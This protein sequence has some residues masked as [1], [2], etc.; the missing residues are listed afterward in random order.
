MRIFCTGTSGYIG[1]SVAATLVA[2]GH[3]VSG[4]VRST[5][6]AEQVRSIGIEP[7]HGALDDLDCL[8]AAAKAADVIVNAASADHRGAATALLQALEGTGK[9]Y[10]HT[11]GSSIVGTRSAGTRSDLVYNEESPFTP[12]PGR[13]ARVV[14]NE[15]IL[16]HTGK[17]L[18]PIII[19]PSLI[20]GLGHGVKR[21]SM[22]VP[23]LI[24]VAKKH[25][26]SKHYGPG[27]NIWSNVHIDDVV[28][29]YLL[30]MANAPAGA[31]YFAE[32]GENSMREVCETISRMLG[33]GGRTET[34]TIEEA[35][36][37][38]GEN[39]AHDTM[40]SNSRVRAIRARRELGWRPT[41]PSLIEEIEHGTYTEVA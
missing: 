8:K 27:D 15:F 29:L 13:A 11:S 22:Q 2:A 38:W 40:G 28:R 14:L 5:K 20:Y 36:A 24:A 6:S 35:T 16:S 39:G 7:I 34:M 12:S 17:G 23:W 3:S 10:V 9:T 33:F 21:H 32:H 19:C 41:A 25:G 37:E 30:A 26:V 4:L 31:F 18:R 1:G